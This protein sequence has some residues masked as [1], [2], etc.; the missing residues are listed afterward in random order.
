MTTLEPGARVVSTQGLRSRPRS[1]AFFASSAAPSMTEGFEVLVHEVIAAI[2]TA[3]WS[4]SNSA[5][6]RETVTGLL[7]RPS[8]PS[9]AD[10]A[11]R[12]L[13]SPF[14]PSPYAGGSLAGN[15]SAPA[16]STLDVPGPGSVCATYDPS[17]PRNAGF[18]PASSMRSCGRFGPAIDG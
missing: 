16:S 12:G 7:G 18:A 10:A 15:V 5:P 4:S 17:A 6:S 14:S 3:P 13:P 2:A 1:T 8:L 9:A 11:T